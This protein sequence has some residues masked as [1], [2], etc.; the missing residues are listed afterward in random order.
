M[1]YLKGLHCR[2]SGEIESRIQR[3][4]LLP[5]RECRRWVSG[6]GPGKVFDGVVVDAGVAAG[7]FGGIVFGGMPAGTAAVPAVLS[8]EALWMAC[9]GCRGGKRI[10]PRRQPDPAQ[11]I[12]HGFVMARDRIATKRVC[13]REMRDHR[14]LLN[15]GSMAGVGLRNRRGGYHQERKKKKKVFG[16]GYKFRVSC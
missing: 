8:F 13:G 11:R 12:P 10:F 2:F 14:I 7:A 5:E 4:H 15:H 16:H 1:T 3:Q 6:G 9:G